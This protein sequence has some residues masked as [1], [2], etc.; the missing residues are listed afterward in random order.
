MCWFV[1]LLTA[2][3]VA[4]SEGIFRLRSN[5]ELCGL[6]R[7]PLFT[8][9]SMA[10]GRWLLADERAH[11]PNNNSSNKA[12]EEKRETTTITTMAS[13]SRT[14]ISFSALAVGAA[15]RRSSDV[16]G[17]GGHERPSSAGALEFCAWRCAI[18][19][20]QDLGDEPAHSPR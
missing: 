13:L 14:M 11:G 12:K 7:G 5:G 9:L 3:A 15:Y 10:D 20:G 6:K 4:A 19:S 18:I 8:G 17:L 16:G 1:R 2:I